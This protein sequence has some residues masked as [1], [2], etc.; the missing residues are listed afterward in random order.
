MTRISLF[1]FALGMEVKQPSDITIPRMMGYHKDD[2]RNA[3]IMVEECKEVNICAKKVL[4]EAQ[5]R[6]EKLTNKSRRH[7]QFEVGDF[8]MLNIHNFKMPKALV[9]CFIPKYIGSYKVTHKPH[10]NV[11]TLLATTFIAHPTFHVSKLK[12]FKANDKRLKRK[13]EYHKGFNFMEH[14]LTAEIECI[15]SVKQ[16]QRC[17]KQYIIKWKGCHPR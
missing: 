10:L 4:E 15:L 2:G 8:V 12:L 3:K 14:W 13:H 11:Y 1:E 17:G 6:Y 7:I 16:T 5:T 9:A